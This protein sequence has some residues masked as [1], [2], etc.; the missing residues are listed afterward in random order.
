[1]EGANS[2]KVTDTS[3]SVSILPFWLISFTPLGPGPFSCSLGQWGGGFHA[4][5]SYVFGVDYKASSH[6]LCKVEK[7]CFTQGVHRS[8]AQLRF[9]IRQQRSASV[10]WND[11]VLCVHYQRGA[12]G[13]SDFRFKRNGHS[14]NRQ[15]GPNSYFTV[16]LKNVQH[17]S[18]SVR[19]NVLC[20][21]V[22]CRGF[23]RR[24]PCLCVSLCEWSAIASCLLHS[25]LW[26]YM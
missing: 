1:M 11:K 12:T 8:S 23:V 2:H 14:F 7:L 6:A 4:W 22:S 5:Q 25:Q 9:Q 17:S 20:V 26:V 3:K 10:Q 19:S 21:N 24:P 18:K 16:H 13:N 15:D